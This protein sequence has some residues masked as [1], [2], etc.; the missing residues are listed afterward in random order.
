M[1]KYS[2]LL[3]DP[4]EV[5]RRVFI[6]KTRWQMVCAAQT[7][8]ILVMTVALV[9]L[10]VRPPAVIVK[11]RLHGEPAILK[12]AAEE[13]AIDEVDARIFFIN[14]LKLRFSWDSLTVARDM[15]AYLDQCYRDQREVES[16][17]LRELVEQQLGG[18]DD[19]IPRLAF[20]AKARIANTLVLPEHIDDVKCLKKDTIWHC[21]VDGSIIT[22]NLGVPFMQ[23]PA[24]QKSTF[25]ATLLEVPHTQGTPYGLIIGALRQFGRDDPIRKESNG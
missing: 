11:D 4:F 25:V 17:H 15:R 23:P 2:P 18:S 8:V 1:I 13:P 9:L 10:A 16:I 6:D 3:A 7:L 14:M 22:Q 24:A 5:H 20:W 12:I 21:N 19:K